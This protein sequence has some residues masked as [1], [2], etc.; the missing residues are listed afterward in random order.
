MN[1]YL[2]C[3]PR[4]ADLN[5]HFFDHFRFFWTINNLVRLPKT[6]ISR[7][8]HFYKQKLSIKILVD[9]N[10]VTISLKVS[11]V[12][13]EEITIEITGLPDQLVLDAIL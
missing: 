1:D 8:K 3:N 9:E 2:S 12:I 13:T 4:G 5:D 6:K 11:G 10:Q 7:S